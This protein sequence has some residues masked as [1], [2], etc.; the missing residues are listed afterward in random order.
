MPDQTTAGAGIDLDDTIRCPI[1]GHCEHCGRVV[2]DLAVATLGTPLGVYCATLCDQCAEPELQTTKGRTPGGL[3]GTRPPMSW[4][5]AA[6][7]VGEHCEH[8]GID[9][10]QMA[11]ALKAEAL[12]VKER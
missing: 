4:G 1:L 9:L 10:D 8:L 5:E 2:A 12:A 3:I 6:S 7:R 11:D